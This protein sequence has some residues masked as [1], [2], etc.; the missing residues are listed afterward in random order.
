MR[1]DKSNRVLCDVRRHTEP[2]HLNRKNSECGFRLRPVFVFYRFSYLICKLNVKVHVDPLRYA[3]PC[4]TLH[5]KR[6]ELPLS[7]KRE[8]T[9]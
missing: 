2:G 8:H 3:Y 5:R 4:N 6:N 9:E 1:F 7:M